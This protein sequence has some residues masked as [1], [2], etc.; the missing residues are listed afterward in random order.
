L[1]KLKSFGDRP[2]E[3]DAN[4][5]KHYKVSKATAHLKHSF[6]DYDC[7]YRFSITLQ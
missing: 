5:F 2:L 7:L 4:F 1:F 3:I 6:G